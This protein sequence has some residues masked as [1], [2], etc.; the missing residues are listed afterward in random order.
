MHAVTPHVCP[1]LSYRVMYLD[2]Y[3]SYVAIARDWQARIE[4]PV[5]LSL[6]SIAD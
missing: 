6:V 2:Q 3:A 4:S 5:Y 1:D